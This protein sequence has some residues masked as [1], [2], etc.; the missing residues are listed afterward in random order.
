MHRF[1]FPLR[2]LI[3][4]AIT[5]FVF[6][7]KKDAAPQATTAP[8]AAKAL[9][10][11][12]M[13]AAPQLLSA[14]IEVPGSLMANESTDIHPEVSGRMVQL[15]INEGGRVAK[16]ALLAKLYDGDLQAQMR[17]LEVQL[18]I[19]EQTEKRQAE[20]L[21]IQ[22]ISQNDY[23]LSL[24]QVLNLKADMDIIKESIRKTE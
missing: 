17:K 20:L 12:I 9:P 1:P 16:G 2:V 5:S 23:D 21:K 10:V 11:Q 3:F 18:K 6:C 22:G 7:K 8:V 19:A 24:L 14:D 13:I 4:L 15:H